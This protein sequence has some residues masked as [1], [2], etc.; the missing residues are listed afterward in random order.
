MT[1]IV[2][3]GT[4][5]VSAVV[6]AVGIAIPTPMWLQYG[7][8]GLCALMI[9]M[10]Y[11]DRRNAIQRLDKE[12]DTKDTLAKATLGTL[13]RLSHVMETKPCL[14]S[15]AVLREVREAVREEMKNGR[16]RTQGA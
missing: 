12:R 13:N 2:L 3:L 11:A 8:L 9:V 15:D 5:G 4:A 6:S 14:M 7:A 10:N 16:E 1:H